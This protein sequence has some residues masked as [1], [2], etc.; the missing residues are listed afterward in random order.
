METNSVSPQVI[1]IREDENEVMTT[2][3]VTSMYGSPIEAGYISGRCKSCDSIHMMYGEF[4]QVDTEPGRGM[5]TEVIYHI[6]HHAYC[7]RCKRDLFLTSIFSEYPDSRLRFLG[8]DSEEAVYHNI[9]QVDGMVRSVSSDTDTVYDIFNSFSNIGNFIQ[10]EADAD[11]SLASAIQ[12]LRNAAKNSVIV[13]GNFDEPYKEELRDLRQSLN[14]MGYEAYLVDDLGERTED[15]VDRAARLLMNMASFCVMV[16][17]EPSGHLVEY[18][19]AYDDRT[20]LAR[21][22]PASRGRASSAM[23]A[24]EEPEVDFLEDFEFSEAPSEVLDE[25]VEWAE[26]QIEKR[27]ERNIEKFPWY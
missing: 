4:K 9:E 5:G 15:S 24:S 21:L 19:Y 20:I 1:L 16:D 2:Q 14:S 25:L 8:V 12:N 11:N 26:E 10:S 13:L 27:Q 23:I 17:R 7:E 18:K 3:G 6:R 22:E